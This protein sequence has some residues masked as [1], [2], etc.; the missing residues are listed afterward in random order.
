MHIKLK[1]FMSYQDLTIQQPAGRVLLFTGPN[2]SGKSTILD[3]VRWALVGTARDYAK[4]T[5]AAAALKGDPGKP[6]SVSVEC[7]ANWGQWPRALQRA[8]KLTIIPTEVADHYKATA[9]RVDAILGVWSLVQTSDGSRASLMNAICRAGATD[10]GI[11]AELKA[12][13]LPAPPIGV[14]YNDVD[15]SN[16][17]DVATALQKAK[18]IRRGYHAAKS[19]EV[20]QEMKDKLE[21]AKAELAALE[22]VDKPPPCPSTLTQNEV[23]TLT[24]RIARDGGRLKFLDGHLNE[25]ISR[26]AAHEAAR[27]EVEKYR[28]DVVVSGLKSLDLEMDDINKRWGEAES[29]VKEHDDLQAKF[30]ANYKKRESLTNKIAKLENDI[31]LISTNATQA[32]QKWDNWDK[33]VGGLEPSGPVAAAV[34]AKAAVSIDRERLDWAAKELGLAITLGND[35]AITVGSRG[36]NVASHAQNMLAGLALQDALCLAAGIPLMLVDEMECLVGDNLQRAMNFLNAIAED[37]EGILAC[38]A[39]PKLGN[40]GQNVVQFVCGGGRLS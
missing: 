25:I 26:L 36:R 29:I 3:A 40:L 38:H 22:T 35:G 8:S 32:K 16:F 28:A 14:K 23:D 24:A 39:G 27:K 30:D 33:V 31:A 9:D 34:M 2:A 19:G 20:P 1:N 10:E 18:D 6:M 17:G 37:Y 21:A 4:M 7:I 13:K 15:W 11:L 12:A 5:D